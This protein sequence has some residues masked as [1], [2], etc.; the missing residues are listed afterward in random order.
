VEQLAMDLADLR[1][2]RGDPTDDQ[3]VFPAQGGKYWSKSQYNNWRN[4]VWKSAMEKLAEGD[5]P[6]QE[7][8]KIVG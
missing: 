2:A 4:R 8:S 3:I 5:P 6:C 7:A 1:A